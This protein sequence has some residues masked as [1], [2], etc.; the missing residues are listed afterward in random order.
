[1]K[2]IKELVKPFIFIIFGAL[3]FLYYFNGLSGE[4]AGLAISIIAIIL[5]AYFLT[6]GILSVVLGDKLGKAKGLLNL[7][8]V[9]TFPLFYFVIELITLI[10]LADVEGFLGP[11]GWTISILTLIAALGL[12]ALLFVSY[13]VR[14][15][16][17]HRV[18]FLFGAIFV[19]ALLLDILLQV[20]GTPATIG[21]VVIL[22]VVLYGAYVSMMFDILSSL[23]ENKEPKKV[24]EKKE[25]PKEE[26]AEEPAE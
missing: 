8:G 17:L 11:T 14:S 24:E 6:V 13:F 21:Q 26:P 10:N 16:E 23:K 5:A 18:T 12:G 15:K 9:A 1:M 22:Q 25:E 2:K 19:L 7:I 4:G 3:L 20:D